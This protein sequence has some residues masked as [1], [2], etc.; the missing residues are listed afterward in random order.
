[1]HIIKILKSTNYWT[2]LSI[3][4]N[5]RANKR[6]NISIKIFLIQAKNE[7]TEQ[8]AEIAEDI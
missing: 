1:M 7:S 6:E 5:K 3:I 2:Y 8:E 4:I